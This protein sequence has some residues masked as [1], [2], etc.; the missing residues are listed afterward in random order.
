MTYLILSRPAPAYTRSRYTASEEY[1]M[2]AHEA[3]AHQ[4]YQTAE[5]RRPAPLDLRRHQR[6]DEGQD[7]SGAQN[8]TTA[9]LRGYH[10]QAL[11]GRV[12][13][14]IISLPNITLSSSPQLMTGGL[15]S[16]MSEEDFHASAAAVRSEFKQ[17]LRSLA[18]NCGGDCEGES[19][20]SPSTLYSIIHISILLMSHVNARSSREVSGQ[21]PQQQSSTRR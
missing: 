15:S 14:E 18:E 6:G 2:R 10:L 3:Q 19:R 20:M 1:I 16:T 8:T 5:R 7:G 17:Q 21:H 9:G 12:G 11:I 4:L 13:Q